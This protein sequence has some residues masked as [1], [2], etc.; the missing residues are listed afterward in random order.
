MVFSLRLFLVRRHTAT[1]NDCNID[2]DNDNVQMARMNGEM[3]EFEDIDGLRDEAART[4]VC[5]RTHMVGWTKQTRLGKDVQYIVRTVGRDHSGREEENIFVFVLA[6]HRL[7]YLAPQIRQARVAKWE[8]IMRIYID[9][10]L[11]HNLQK[12]RNSKRTNQ[13]LSRWIAFSTHQEHLQELRKQYRGRVEAMRGQVQQLTARHEACKK[14]LAA[15]ETV[16]VC[17]TMP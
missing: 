9:C 13:P 4:K 3:R 14:E 6:W 11:M 1:N 12:T 7:D 10:C 5:V 8:R 2:N 16:S 15:S 17:R